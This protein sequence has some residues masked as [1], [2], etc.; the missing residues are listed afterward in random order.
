MNRQ[1]QEI[2]MKTAP[3]RLKNLSCTLLL[4]AGAWSAPVAL[5]AESRSQRDAA[6]SEARYQSDAAV[7]LSRRYVGDKDE[8]LSEASTARASREPFKVDPDP[9]RYARN[10]LKRCE[11]LPD[12]DREACLTRMRGGGT[13]SGS[14]A[15]GGIYRELVT[16]ETTA[17]P[18]TPA[19]PVTPATPAMPA[20]PA[21][22]AMPAMPAT[23]ATPATPAMPAK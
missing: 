20:L 18:A 10:A 13:T 19:T 8:C 7:C 9:G 4:L 16:R 3:N 5:A 14:V 15:G 2:R 22:P 23:P 11:P 17:V 6:R 21:M 1:P 12:A